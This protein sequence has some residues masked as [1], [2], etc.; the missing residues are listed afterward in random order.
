MPV[1]MEHNTEKE[2]AR[3]RGRP[4]LAALL[5][6]VGLVL[7]LLLVPVVHPVTLSYGGLDLHS[8]VTRT[9]GRPGFVAVEYIEGKARVH[10]RELTLGSWTYSV[11]W[12]VGPPEPWRKNWAA[13]IR[14]EAAEMELRRKAEEEER[15]WL[16]RP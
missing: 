11:V 13:R 16:E 12:M 1:T 4:W 14:E 8:S 7:L 5:G 9:H 6:V 15:R 10:Q 2:K 3:R